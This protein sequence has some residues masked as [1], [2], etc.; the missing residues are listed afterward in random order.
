MQS[1]TIDVPM[2]MM[3]E[4]CKEMEEV[5]Q[6]MLMGIPDA[7]VMASVGSQTDWGSDSSEEV[8]L[9]NFDFDLQDQTL[10]RQQNYVF[11]GESPTGMY[12]SWGVWGVK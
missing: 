11:Q 3:S 10:D 4:M 6:E 12:G 9:S 8:S 5:S 2:D 7:A 1:L